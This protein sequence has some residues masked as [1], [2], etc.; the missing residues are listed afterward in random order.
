MIKNKRKK[1]GG[2]EKKK[3][4]PLLFMCTPFLLVYK[5]DFLNECHFHP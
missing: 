1:E 2:N 4:P 5:L 3:T